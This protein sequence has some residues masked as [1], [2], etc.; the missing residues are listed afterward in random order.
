MRGIRQP[1]VKNLQELDTLKPS[2]KW[3][4][5][6]EDEDSD[7]YYDGE[8]AAWIEIP[9]SSTNYIRYDEDDKLAS[10]KLMFNTIDINELVLYLIIMVCIIGALLTNHPEVAS[11]LAGVL[12][13]RASGLLISPKKNK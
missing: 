12:S 13:G 11:M 3:I 2:D 6:V 9:C 7:F 5:R 4:V 1:N 8:K 10:N